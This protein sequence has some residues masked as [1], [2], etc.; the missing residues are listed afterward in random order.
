MYVS[1][2]TVKNILDTDTNVYLTVYYDDIDIIPEN[3]KILSI[4]S[5]RYSINNLPNT[6]QKLSIGIIDN[7]KYGDI[8]V[9]N[10]G[11]NYNLINNIYNQSI[12]SSLG[13]Y[14]KTD[15]PATYSPVLDLSKL[16]KSIK[17]LTLCC[18]FESLDFLHENIKILKLLYIKNDINDLPASINE[19]W[20]NKNDIDKI[21]KIYHHKIHFLEERIIWN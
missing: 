7:I 6:I 10:D 14:Y 15:T 21:N 12:F 17:E 3:I 1:R 16:P 2:D 8:G 9:Y 5:C 18:D 20:I 11:E 13:F 19:I 4:L